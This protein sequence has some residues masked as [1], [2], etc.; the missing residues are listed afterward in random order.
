MPQVVGTI[1][2]PRYYF[3]RSNIACIT[4]SYGEHGIGRQSLERQAH[5]G[6]FTPGWGLQGDLGVAPDPAAGNEIGVPPFGVALDVV[7]GAV[8]VQRAV[9]IYPAR[10]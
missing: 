9:S 2:L 7:G 5:L 3:T 10:R 4:A 8:G 1:N 6:M